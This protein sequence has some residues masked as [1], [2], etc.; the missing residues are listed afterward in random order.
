VSH[1]KSA[2]RLA[3]L[4]AAFC[5][6]QA[7]AEPRFSFSTTPG[8][9]PKE[10]IPKHYSLR[11]VP[12]GDRFDAEVAI[13]IEVAKPV[14]AIV[15]NAAE[16]SFKSAKLR[17]GGGDETSL[18]P[19]F[20]PQQ[21][22]VALRPARGEI[23]AGSYRLGIDYSGKIGR[24][25]QGLYRIDYKQNEGT[26]IVG[27]AMLATQMEPVSARRLFPGWDEPV[28]RATFEIAAVTDASLTVVSN[29]P[30]SGTRSL[31]GGKKEVS[32]ARS[33]PMST[34]LV[35][36][37][38]GEM[39]FL[40]GEVDGIKLRIYTA[41]GK[42]ERARYAMDSTK[43]IVRYYNEYFAEP[44]PLPKLDQI[45][46][47]GG[48]GGAMENWGAIAY[49]EARFLYD[50]RRDSVRQQQANYGIIAHEIAH[51]WFGN[52]V[53]MAWWDN[54]W[55]NEG[56]ATWMSAK[57]T[58]RFNPQWAMRARYALSKEWALG[59]DARRTTHAVQ[60]AVETDVRASDVF[61]SISYAKGAA[62]LRM[63]EAYLGE[64]TFRAGMRRYV[65]EHR[66]SNT[67]TADLWRHLSEASGQDVGKLVSGWTEQPGYPVVK[68][69]EDCAHDGAV[70]TV[71]QERFTLNDP[72]ASPLKWNVPVTLADLSGARRTVLLEGASQ[73]LRFASC[74]IVANAGD[75]G[76]YRVQYDDASFGKL[77]SG[78]GSLPALDRLRLLSDTFALVLAGRAEVTRYL[79]LVDRLGAETDRAIWDQVIGSLRFL[80]DLIDVPDERAAFDRF[81]VGVLEKPF[82]RVGWDARRGE[83]LDVRP[84]RRSLIDA[85]GRSGDRAVV[86]EAQARFAARQR[87]PIDAAIQ[88]AVLN[89][90]GRYADEA[91]FKA[92]LQRMRTA[93]DVED[94]SD[95]QSALRQIQDPRLLGQLMELMMTDELPPGEAVFNLTHIGSEGGQVELSWQF[96]LSRLPDILAKASPRG[97]PLVLPDAASGFSDAARASELISLT[98]AHLETPALYQAEKAAD[99]IRLKATVKK[100]EAARA[101]GWA[102]AHSR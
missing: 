28:F 74:R 102:R 39:D 97:R 75:D 54:V 40:E 82:A 37:F 15:L 90:A 55:L 80:S 9:L 18:T 72:D 61:D 21:E 32:F 22:T 33:V 52:L 57:V 53:T 13:D 36:L 87:E 1:E 27:K 70:V 20:D 51:Q 77:A 4:A 92:L 11:V 19:V 69:S 83:A 47:P 62:V 5:F 94:K 34:Y 58:D 12:E 42:R 43:Q 93:T 91:M 44:Y 98:R 25:T 48:I 38:I 17:A 31:P 81:A 59:E 66:F 24:H 46:L 89:V 71:D 2:I 68:V 76:Y 96:V 7:G 86:R 88:S 3:A 95:A 100:R 63:V 8:K 35:A 30:Q 45:A 73:S 101:V 64:D 49:S 16:L 23:A 99:W 56:F 26:R 67:T 10:V 79:A 50:P 78:L 84:L 60:T 29:M 65:R 6:A 85:L 41:K 14:A